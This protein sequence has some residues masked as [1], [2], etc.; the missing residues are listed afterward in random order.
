MNGR[1]LMVED[2]ARMHE[3]LRDYFEAAGYEVLSAMDGVEALALFEREPVDVV[4]LD[5]M[6]PRLDGWTVCRRIRQKSDVLVVILSAR[7]EEDDKLMGFELGADE[8]VTKPFSPK[9]LVAAVAALLRR[10]RGK[11][12]EERL[13]RLAEVELDRERYRVMVSGEDASLTTREFDMLQLLMENP[14]RV[15]RRDALILAI[16]GYDYFGDGR[17]V[18]TNIKTLRRKLGVAGRYIQTV[19]GIGYKFEVRI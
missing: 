2:D 4:L 1:I 7:S 14:G 18:D 15:Y 11:G 6:M 10:S 8:Y 5:I 16:W 13:I 17:V 12:A 3:I 9:V 19:I